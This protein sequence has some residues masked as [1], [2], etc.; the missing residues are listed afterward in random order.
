MEAEKID[1]FTLKSDQ[2]RPKLVDPCERS[3]NREAPFVHVAIEMSLPTAFRRFPT[4][5][6]F[7][8]V[9]NNTS[10]P[11]HLACSTRVKTTVRIEERSLIRQLGPLQISKQFLERLRQLIRIVVIASNNIRRRQNIPIAVDQA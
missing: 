8:N 11:E 2:Q 1:I 9:R 5:F 3:L 4:T 7:S 6:V 10:I